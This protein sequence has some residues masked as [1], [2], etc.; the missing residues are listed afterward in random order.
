MF[1]DKSRYKNV[2]VYEVKDRRNRTV[3]VVATP[4]APSQNIMGNHML[5]QGQHID[6]LAA[7]YLNDSAGSWRIAEAND[8]MLTESLSERSEIAIPEKK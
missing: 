8:V 4:P 2:T 3:K 1:N 5:K 7:R 6:H